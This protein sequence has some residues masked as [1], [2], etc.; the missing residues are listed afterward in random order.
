MPFD[1]LIVIGGVAAGTKAAATARRRNPKASVI[2]LQDEVDVSYSAC[3]MPYHIASSDEIPRKKLIARTAE[4]FRADGID[5]RT[6]HRVEEIDAKRGTVTV[7]DLEGGRSYTESYDQLLIATGAQAAGLKATVSPTAPAVT[8]LRTLAD[9][10]RIASK[11]AGIRKLVI[12]GG[13]YIGLEMAETAKKLG[14]EVSVV[15]MAPRVI[16][17][18]DEAVS[19]LVEDELRRNGVEVVTGSRVVELDGGHVVLENGDR[20]AADMVLVA[21]GVRPATSLATTA[22]VKLGIT[23]AIAV[24]PRMATNVKR[25]YA[26]GDCAESH[27]IVSDR[28]VWMPLGD[29]ANRQGRVAGINMSGGNAKFP[30]V[31]GTAIFR[32]FDLSV[33]RTGLG[34]ADARA[35]LIEPISKTINAPSR[36]RYMV[37]STP[38]QIHLTVHRDS[39][40][41][42]GCEVVGRDAVDKTVDTIAA[43]IWGKLNVDDLLD[44]DL[45]YAP[46][47]SPVFAPVQVA[48]EVLGKAVRE[49]REQIDAAALRYMF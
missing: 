14:M 28:P 18:F 6:G 1:R 44:L 9:A 26:A 3:G 46:P 37:G 11:L 31:L 32:V 27:H 35:A 39:G 19:K 21:T 2:V 34:V 40:K 48:G 33:A 5:M 10:D 38:L 36:A 12:L 4:A 15:E 30:G 49:V 20:I 8:Q 43:A 7:R 47:F 42:L 45:A 41:L 23:G 22:G 16:P 24:S 17:T 13:G 25:I 29:V